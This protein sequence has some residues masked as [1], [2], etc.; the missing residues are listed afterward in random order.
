MRPNTKGQR[1]MKTLR[2]LALALLTWAIFIPQSGF[3]QQTAGTNYGNFIAGF[4][5]PALSG[6]GTATLTYTAGTLYQ[7]GAAV[8]IAASTS[9]VDSSESSCAAPAYS[10]CDIF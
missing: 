9:S 6:V 2:F 10:G 7:G 4:A 8:T 3:A 5:A 1:S